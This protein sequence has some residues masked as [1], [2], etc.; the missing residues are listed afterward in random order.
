MCETLQNSSGNTSENSA[1][2]T[3]SISGQTTSERQLRLVAG[4]ATTAGIKSVNEDAAI[5]HWPEGA[6]LQ[7]SLGAVAAVADGVSSAEAGARASKT[8]TAQ[9]VADYFN[10]PDT[11]P[12]ARAGE[13][14]LTSIN[15]KLYRLSHEF[16]QEEKGF[17]CTFSALVIK[18][19]TAHFFHVGDSRIYLLRDDTLQCLT[20]DHVVMLGGGRCMLARALGM[21]T[22]LQVDY[23]QQ[24]LEVGDRLLLTSDGVH[25]F[26]SA[27]QLKTALQNTELSPQQ[28][29]EQ[30]IE[31]ALAGGSDDNLSALVVAVESLPQ[32][33]LDEYSRKLTRL[34]FPPPLEPGMVLDGYAIE[35]ELFSSQRSQLYLVRDTLS[36]TNQTLVMKTP[37]V[38]Y[39]DDIHYIDRFVHEEWI[40]LRIQ[41]PRVVKVQR[42]QRPR[43]ALYYLMEY[44]EG[45]TLEQWIAN[46]RFPK[47]ADAYHIVCEI[48]EGLKAFH[49][50]ETIHQDLRPANLMI[51][52]NGQVKIIDFGSVYVAGSA[53]VFRPLQHPG[54][55]GT[56]SYSDPHYI[57]GRN[58]GIQGDLY[59]LA[60][61]AYE[62]FT[63][64][65]P[66][67]EAINDCRSRADYEQLRYR[68]TSQFN[69]VVPIW[70]DRT[71]ERG[72]AID[73]EQRYR[74]VDTFV[75]D[76]GTPNPM[77]LQD[78]PN[79]Q[80]SQHASLFWKLL[81]GLWGVA[82]LALLAL[83]SSG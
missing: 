5:Y 35:R 21:D 31:Q 26:L 30:L 10:A 65:L 82:L 74:S 46:N 53:E 37:S 2:N 8:A 54:A 22:G 55:L 81:C 59:A 27:E 62:L 13:R 39:E 33:T 19:R 72:C 29:S 32:T 44:V 57:L 43:T 24:A 49:D 73:L 79:D 23:G 61:V 77:Y 70:F 40:G 42:Q 38:N 69:P 6:H 47:P 56:A 25:D 36:E 9:F 16:S 80:Q 71:L 12:A 14:A 7:D 48:A 76:L 66:Y 78:D 15:S 52:R 11:W 18:S 67:G 63:G 34:P 68:S 60:T 17:L 58:S 20:R 28:Q 50:Q 4:V 83:F 3:E 45:E 51:E 75:Q 64:E 41:H 1:E